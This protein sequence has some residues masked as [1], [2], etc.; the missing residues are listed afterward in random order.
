M[1]DTPCSEVVWRVLATHSIHQF[2]LHFPS[3]ASPCAITFQLCSI[4]LNT[5]HLL[6]YFLWLGDLLFKHAHSR[7]RRPEILPEILDF[8]CFNLSILLGLNAVIVLQS[9]P[10][11]LHFVSF[12]VHSSLILFCH[13]TLYTVLSQLLTPSF[14]VTW[15]YILYCHSYWHHQ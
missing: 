4:S 14:S 6:V 13:L 12:P 8:M 7:L 1:L 2:P 9:R 5:V 3:R 10:G 15:H 11:A